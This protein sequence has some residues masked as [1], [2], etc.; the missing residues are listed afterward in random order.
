MGF[1][2]RLFRRNKVK[3]A[4]EI[5]DWEQLIYDRD[6][7]DFRDEEQRSRYITNC[8]E[9]IAEASKEADLLSGE[10]SLVTSYLSD[11]E[12]IELLP[13][14]DREQLNEPARREDVLEKEC[15]IYQGKKERMKDSDFQHMKAQEGEILEGIQKLKDCEHYGELVKQDLKRIDR[16]KHAY[17]YRRVE[18][19]TAMNNFRGMAVIF[20][21]AFALCILLLLILQ[22]GFEMDTKVG[23][24]LALGIVAVAVTVLVVKYMD[25]EQELKRVE[26]TFNKLIQLQNKVKIRY[27][28]NNNLLEYL[29]MK[30]NV[31]SAAV[32]E[33]RWAQFQ[34]EKEE[35]REY[36]EA[37]AKATYYRE[38][39][40][41]QLRQYHITDPVRWV[42]QPAALLDKREI[43][44]MR[45]E[46][47][48]RRQ[49]LRKQLDYNN[50]I[51]SKARDEIKDVVKRYPAYAQEILSMVEKYDDSDY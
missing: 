31:E 4:D 24:L 29:R 39:L 40:L 44:E 8:L 20:M 46:L 3:P 45:H 9:Q 28:N 33:K 22:F 14:R 42:N 18:L 37:E 27:V 34:E 35:R 36:A 6:M 11:I 26:N 16:E 30:Y 23:I 32:L 41:S 25:R 47:I 15:V 1:W 51:A 43:V 49:A 7:V 21:T 17:D 2:S 38:Q 12:E 48:L 5:D 19:G 50:Q 10:Y 13:E